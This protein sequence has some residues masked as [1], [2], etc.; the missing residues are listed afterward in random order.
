MRQKPPHRL[1][2]PTS[3][4][5]QSCADIED[6]QGL[7]L[8]EIS[9][10]PLLTRVQEQHLARRVQ[11]GDQ[12]ALHQFIVA[13]LPLVV[14]IAKRYHGHGLELLDLI[15]EGSI[16]L[17]RAVNK[18]DP[19][20]G[21]RFSTM[22]T[23]W[24]RRAIQVAI[25]DQG[26]LIRLPISFQERQQA[27]WRKQAASLLDEE[28]AL[29]LVEQG[30]D[31]SEMS[32]W[33]QLQAVYS[34]DAAFNQDQSDPLTLSE[35][36]ADPQATEMLE[37]VEEQASRP[38][39]SQMLQHLPFRD[40]QVLILHLGLQGEPPLTLREVGAIVGLSSEGVRLAEQ[41]ALRTLRAAVS[42]KK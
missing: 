6:I 33:P 12:E 20:R 34:L 31:S 22:A 19:T 7:Y 41:R 16:G 29:L 37:Q 24:I 15:Q 23:W 8:R 10:I 40:R 25:A 17:M 21:N 39:L 13:N 36:F 30:E 5:A 3:F 14:S 35:L 32:A 2:P 18:F 26:R 27:S 28:D 38:T 11:S 42:G 1:L 4:Q 9:R